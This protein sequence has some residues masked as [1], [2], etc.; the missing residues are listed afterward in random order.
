MKYAVIV[1]RVLLGFVFLFFGLNHFL[2]FYEMPQP[3]LS[4]EAASL[5]SAFVPTG[6]LNVVKVLEVAGGLL[7][8]AGI[9]VPLGLVLLTPVIVNI[10]LF[11]TLL[12]QQPGLGL[13]LLALALFLIFA[14]RDYFT[15]LFTL[16]A[17][18][19]V[20]APPAE[21]SA[22]VPSTTLGR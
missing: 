18:P 21:T 2:K 22:A 10:F 5:M 14:Y 7:L 13:P 17:R 20:F 3:N 4:K 15:P 1:A 6:Y 11:D 16:H 19:A 8:V 12:M 9:F